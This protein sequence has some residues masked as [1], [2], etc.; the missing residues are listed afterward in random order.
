MHDSY[1]AFKTSSSLTSACFT[2]SEHR[3][4]LK[5][6]MCPNCKSKRNTTTLKLISFLE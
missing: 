3:V 5:H 2:G 4:C 1:L 6:F